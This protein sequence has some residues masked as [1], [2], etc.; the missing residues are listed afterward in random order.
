[1]KL[2]LICIITCLTVGL[3]AQNGSTRTN[4]QEG[5]PDAKPGFCYLKR[6][7]GTTKPEWKAILCEW[8][9]FDTLNIIQDEL[10]P[11]LTNYDKH[12]INKRVRQ[13][14][15]R[16]LAIEVQSYY[17][18][19]ASDATDACLAQARAIAVGE[20]LIQEGLDRSQ[21]KITALPVGDKNSR[22]LAVRAIQARPVSEASQ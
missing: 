14:L 11:R 15:D 3:S 20:Y 18:S 4:T 19:P 16:N 22:T 8:K 7:V 12:Y 6:Y 5:P 1:M 10:E 13:W 21:L 17:S 2:V 9:E